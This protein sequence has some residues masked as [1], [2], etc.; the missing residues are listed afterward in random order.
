MTLRKNGVAKGQVALLPGTMADLLDL[1]TRKLTLSS[2]A[3]RIFNVQGDEIDFELIGNDDV[4]Y[5]SCGEEFCVPSTPVAAATTRT[6]PAIETQSSEDRSEQVIRSAA[7]AASQ[8]LPAWP[9]PEDMFSVSLLSMMN[10]QA[11][12]AL[13][14]SPSS[15]ELKGDYLRST[16]KYSLDLARATYDEANMHDGHVWELITTNP[17]FNLKVIGRLNEGNDID[18]GIRGSVAQGF[19]G[20][21]DV[22]NWLRTNFNSLSLDAKASLGDDLLLEYCNGPRPQVYCGFLNAWLAVREEVHRWLDKK[23]QQ[24]PESRMIVH[25]CGHSLGGAL[26]TLCALDVVKRGYLARLVTWASPRVGDARFAHMLQSAV[27]T[28][29]LQ[30]A[31]FVNSLDAVTHLPPEGFGFK[32]VCEETRLDAWTRAVMNGPVAAHSLTAYATNLANCFRNQVLVVAAVE[33]VEAMFQFASMEVVPLLMAAWSGKPPGSVFNWLTANKSINAEIEKVGESSR[34]VHREVIQLKHQLGA[35]HGLIDEATS[36]LKQL[37]VQRWENDKVDAVRATLMAVK[38]ACREGASLDSSHPA[39]SSLRIASYELLL[40]L[41]ESVKGFLTSPREES[42]TNSLARQVDVLC[43]GFLAELQVIHK[44]GDAKRY[45]DRRSEIDEHLTACW[46]TLYELKGEGIF[47]LHTACVSVIFAEQ[48]LSDPGKSPPPKKR[49]PK[50]VLVIGECGDGKSTLV[51]HM[52]DPIRSQEAQAGLRVS[53]ITKDIVEYPGM[54]IEEQDFTFLDT[55]GIGDKDVTPAQLMAMLE[56]RLS[57]PVLD[58]FKPPPIHCILVTTKTTNRRVS[59][60]AQVVEM[61]VNK[62]FVGPTK[63]Q[64]VIFVGTMSDEADEETLQFF[65]TDVVPHFFRK[66]FEGDATL[67]A[68][69]CKHDYSELKAALLE[70]PDT[71]LLYERPP[72]DVLSE[73]LAHLLGYEASEVSSKLLEAR[74]EVARLQADYEEMLLAS[75]LDNTEFQEARQ[76]LN[77]RIDSLSSEK[78]FLI[79]QLG[80]AAG[81]SSGGMVGAGA[82]FFFGPAAGGVGAALGVGMGF[83]AAV[84]AHKAN[85]K[86]VAANL[87]GIAGASL[88]PLDPFKAT[89]DAGSKFLKTTLRSVLDRDPSF[90]EYTWK[91]RHDDQITSVN[92]VQNVRKHLEREIRYQTGISDAEITRLVDTISADWI[93]QIQKLE[94]N[95]TVVRTNRAPNLPITSCEFDKRTKAVTLCSVTNLQFDGKKQGNGEVKTAATSVTVTECCRVI[96]GFVKSIECEMAVTIKYWKFASIKE[97]Q[98]KAKAA[99]T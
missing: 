61:L 35:L 11:T 55:P 9:V 79:G 62:G 56:N 89:L 1:A 76:R 58:K 28:K 84:W 17:E 27:R 49:F 98:E 59:L 30:M 54:P 66:A 8:P 71:V 38:T 4:L 80:A 46:R 3:T 5:V 73:A 32:H 68:V 48:I 60:G 42:A 72:I 43:I 95:D 18:L 91:T 29:K 88:P 13:E 65:R 45:Q 70:V 6:E 74:E 21:L 24:L 37:M 33:N 41:E 26:S 22:T 53:G 16:A 85:V 23:R 92:D 78:A 94:N 83:A 40:Y 7:K 82:G 90:Q 63:W 39:L 20:Q 34:L 15:L 14:S 99:M 81:A 64:N 31:R 97:F 96:L 75:A 19:E 36:Q 93:R 67:S 47:D 2:Q 10:V 52:R 44:S 77:A 86:R 12:E 87:K 51:N 50:Y 57:P 69:V 25:C